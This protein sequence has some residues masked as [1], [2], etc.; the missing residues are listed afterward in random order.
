M[1]CRNYMVIEGEEFEVETPE[2][3]GTL[4]D[5]RYLIWAAGILGLLLE[6]WVLSE[7]PASFLC[8]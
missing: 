6:G 5:R 1:E 7:I 2:F 8:S 3:G 4:Q